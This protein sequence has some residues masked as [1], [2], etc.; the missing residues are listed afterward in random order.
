MSV[1]TRTLGKNGPEVAG[2]GF[3]LMSLGNA[4]GYAGSDEERFDFLDRACG[5]GV[6]S[7]LATGTRCFWRRNLATCQI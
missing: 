7:V 6:T 4:Y 2:L 3:G 1:P 5:L